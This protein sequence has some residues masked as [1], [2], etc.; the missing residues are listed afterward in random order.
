MLGTFCTF[1]RVLFLL[2]KPSR[3]RVIPDGNEKIRQNSLGPIFSNRRAKR[4]LPTVCEPSR[5]MSFSRRFLKTRQE[6]HSSTDFFQCK[7]YVGQS[8]SVRF[9]GKNLISYNG[10][11]CCMRVKRQNVQKVLIFFFNKNK[12]IIFFFLKTSYLE[13]VFFLQILT[14]SSYFIWFSLLRFFIYL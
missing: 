9:L 14:F 7:Y 6:Y 2:F 5:Q 11:R 1:A 8:C 3:K 10:K 13:Q 4:F 12:T